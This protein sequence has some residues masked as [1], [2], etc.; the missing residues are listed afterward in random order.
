M[1]CGL[2]DAMKAFPSGEEGFSENHFKCVL[3]FL[4]ILHPLYVNMHNVILTTDPGQCGEE[5]DWY[6]PD[7]PNPPW[8]RAFYVQQIS[9]CHGFNLPDVLFNLHLHNSS[10]TSC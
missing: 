1:L 6:C 7:I 4:A 8:C 10:N 3:Q 2:L 5:Q 9:C